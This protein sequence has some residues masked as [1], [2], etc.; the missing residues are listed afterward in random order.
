MKHYCA[1]I[2]AIIFLSGCAICRHK[3]LSDY[4]WAI[5]QGYK[6]EIVLYTTTLT[7]RI[8]ALGIWNGHVQAR[9]GDKWISDG[10]L[11]DRPEHPLGKYCWVMNLDQ[12]IDYLS[13]YKRLSAEPYIERLEWP[14]CE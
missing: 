2:A 3:V 13:V 1:L 8:S 4:A 5:K 7:T 10:E 9:T 14:R 6:P 12:Y 11:F